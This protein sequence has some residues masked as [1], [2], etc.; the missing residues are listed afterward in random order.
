MK[1]TVLPLKRQ[2][3][4]HCSPWP[5]EFKQTM[6][7]FEASIIENILKACIWDSYIL[8]IY[9]QTMSPFLSF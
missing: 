6:S 5:I 3:E 2:N 1:D 4:T 8:H 7:T 9:M